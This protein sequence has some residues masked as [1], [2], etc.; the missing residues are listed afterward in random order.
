M[1]KSQAFRRP[2]IGSPTLPDLAIS[3]IFSKLGIEN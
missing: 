1:T 2:N 3:I